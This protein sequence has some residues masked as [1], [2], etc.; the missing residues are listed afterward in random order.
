MGRRFS[1]PGANLTARVPE[2]EK[3]DELVSLSRAFNRMTYQI[4]S[5][6][7]ELMEANRQLDDRRRFTETVLS[8]VSAGVLGLDRDGR[9]NLPN[10]SA[11][12]LLGVDLDLSIG[13]D[14]AEVV[15]EMADLLDAAARRRR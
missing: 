1:S 6:Q 10:R 12:A 14:L 5:Q 7:R 11:S 3:D 9:I 4:Q 8:G 2:G 15:P 13:E